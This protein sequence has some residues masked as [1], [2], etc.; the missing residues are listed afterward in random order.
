MTPREL[1][2]YDGRDGRPAYVAYKGKIYDVSESPMWAEGN[3]QGM[4]QAGRDLTPMLEGAPHGD[5]VF[6]RY[7]V[8]GTLEA[9]PEQKARAD[10]PPPD[11][12]KERR[13]RWQALYRRYHPHPMTVHFPIA[14][15]LFSALMDLL[16]FA[17]PTALYA[18]AVFYTFLAATVMGVVAMVPGL[19]SWRINYGGTWRRPF[20]V[21]I[22]LSVAMLLAGVVAIMLYLE[23][24]GIVYTMSAE[25]IT[26]HAIVLL[27]GAGVIV[28]GYYGGKITWGES[29]PYPQAKEAPVPAAVKASVPTPLPEMNAKL[30]S[31]GR[32][33][34]PFAAD[35]SMPPLQRHVP[36]SPTPPETGQSLSILIGGAAGMGIDTLEK[37]LSD[38]FVRSGYYV[39]SSKEFMSRVRGGSNTTLIRIADAPLE[40]PCW[41]VDLFIALDALALTHAAPRLS[42]QTVVLTDERFASEA[43]GA[44]A[45]AMQREAQRLG[46]PRYANTYA[47]GLVYGM[48]GLETEALNASVQ[49]RFARD[50]GN[51]H[52][53]EA[54]ADVGRTLQHPPLPPLPHSHPEGAAAL[55]LMDGTTACGF[56]FLAGGCN[57]VASYPMSPSTGVLNFMAG[58]SKRFEIAVEQSEDEIASIHLV[59]GAWYAGA[60]ALTTTSGGGFA[61]MGE[62]ISLSGMTET[63]AVVYLAQRPGPATGLPTRSEQGD[64]NLALHSGH[65][66]FPRIILAP[67]SL[68]ECVE[69]GHLA[70]ELADRWQVPVIMLSDQYLADT[71][72]M[73]GD[74]DFAAF[75][76]RR[77]IAPASETY[78][79]YADTPSGVSP[80]AV[81]GGGEGLVCSDGHEHDARGQITEDFR[82][83]EAMVAKRA[84]KAEGIVAEAWAPEVRGAGSIAV[85]GWGSSRGAVAE[86]LARLGDERTCQVHFA[87]VHPLNPEQLAFL[88]TYDYRIVVEN[89]ADGAFAEQLALHG[90]GVDRRIL[91]S[92]GFAFFADQLA[93]ELGAQLK[94]LS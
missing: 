66:P 18:A 65:G 35:P 29:M 47:A 52:A 68:H 39:Y 58:M 91:Q 59:M 87:W 28:L 13:R 6:E 1:A 81:P 37:V 17:V 61:L 33:E 3:H 77:Y 83:R 78:N 84:R 42:A 75:E 45:V 90:V 74:I 72:A 46:D 92:N 76:Q 89:N 49:A 21:K 41:E 86:A 85:I 25:G 11:A 62:G 57:F 60:R 36:A 22:V 8:V 24:P 69:L 56:G 82:V 31:A 50:E 12:N 40:A 88:E 20:A 70:F 27:T 19:I 71:M 80:R 94:E 10:S 26:Y 30:P 16:F 73:T 44:I 67:G 64:L 55:H 7:S 54:G 43:P 23:A 15:H 4:H 14:L 51:V 34:V 48:L 5:E 9:E 38:A 63:P 32:Y 2:A 79:R 93:Q 53:A